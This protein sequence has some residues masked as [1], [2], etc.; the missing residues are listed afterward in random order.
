MTLPESLPDLTIF[1][2]LFGSWEVVLIL[3]VV[4][5]LF[6]RDRLPEL[7][8]GLGQGISWFL[9][10]FEDESHDAGKSLGGIFGKPAVQA[11]TP[12]NQTAELYDPAAFR[13]KQTVRGPARRRW[14][15]WLRCWWRALCRF[16]LKRLRLQRP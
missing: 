12:D 16:V 4:L 8:Q 11:L 6:A 14:T 3:A 13:R 1:A 2:S 9:K 7:L 5:L 10:R 15:R